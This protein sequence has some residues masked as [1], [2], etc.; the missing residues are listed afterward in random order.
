MSIDKLN[1]DAMIVNDIKP[2]KP[3]TKDYKLVDKLSEDTLVSE[4]AKPA[5]R[6]F[7]MVLKYYINEACGGNPLPE[8]AVKKAFAKFNQA[9]NV[10]DFQTI[11]DKQTNFKTEIYRYIDEA[12][13]EETPDFQISRTADED[14][15]REY[16]K[17]A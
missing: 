3:L 8:I 6:E 9:S 4:S 14:A 16:K 2:E 12:L 5:L 7:N 1:L 13:Q 17:A 15:D 11:T 10:V